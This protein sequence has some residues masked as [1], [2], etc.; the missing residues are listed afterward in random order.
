MKIHL[1]TKF[2][3]NHGGMRRSFHRGA[4]RLQYSS[5]KLREVLCVTLWLNIPLIYFYHEGSFFTT[6][7]HGGVFT[8][9]HGVFNIALCNSVTYSAKPRLPTFSLKGRAGLW[10]NT[11]QFYK[12]TLLIPSLSLL[13][14]KLSNNP[15]LHPESFKYVRTCAI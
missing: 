11:L 5:V 3:F 15:I 10:L 14:L 6:E 4:P 13:T 7:V 8:E 9:A 1:L 2:I 12:I